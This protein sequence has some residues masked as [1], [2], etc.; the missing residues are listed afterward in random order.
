[1]RITPNSLDKV[2]PGFPNLTH[3]QMLVRS[4]RV[5]LTEGFHDQPPVCGVN[6]IAISQGS[7]E[8]NISL[9]VTERDAA[10]AVRALHDAFQ[11]ERG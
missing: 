11:L 3:L 4:P 5:A 9:V 1:M 8:R 10:S 6:V 2:P 7:S